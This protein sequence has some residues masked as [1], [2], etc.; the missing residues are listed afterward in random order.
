MARIDWNINAKNRFNIRY[1]Q[2]EGG[3]PNGPSASFSWYRYKCTTGLGRQDITA[4]WFK[5]SN[6]FQGANFYSFSG[7]LNSNLKGF[8]I[9]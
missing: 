3:T 8:Q 5:N 2:V 4:L 1:S 6:Y 7:E 9:H